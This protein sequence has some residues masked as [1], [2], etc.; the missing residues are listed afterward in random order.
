MLSKSYAQVIERESKLAAF[1]EAIKIFKREGPDNFIHAV[2]SKIEQYNVQLGMQP[3]KYDFA[4]KEVIVHHDL[5]IKN[6]D[7]EV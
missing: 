5:I 4:S 1:G 3:F 6:K 2:N 7:S